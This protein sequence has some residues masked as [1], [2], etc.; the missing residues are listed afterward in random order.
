[1]AFQPLPTINTLQTEIIPG[2][3]S[4]LNGQEMQMDKA[5]NL[6]NTNNLDKNLQ[7]I[8]EKFKLDAEHISS[9]KNL[10]NKD[11]IED[12]NQQLKLMKFSVKNSN[13]IAFNLESFETKYPLACHL[14]RIWS[15][16]ENKLSDS[17]CFAQSKHGDIDYN[18][19][20][21]GFDPHTSAD[22]RLRDI[23]QFSSLTNV[24]TRTDDNH[25]IFRRFNAELRSRNLTGPMQSNLLENK[26]KPT[27]RGNN[28]ACV[29]ILSK[30]SLLS[31]INDFEIIYR[32]IIKG[33]KW[34]S[35]IKFLQ[36]VTQKGF[37]QYCGAFKKYQ[38]IIQLEEKIKTWINKYDHVLSA[39][40]DEST[41]NGCG[42]N[43]IQFNAVLSQKYKSDQH[44]LTH[45]LKL[46]NID[47]TKK[48]MENAAK[49]FA[50]HHQL[51]DD[52]IQPFAKYNVC[53]IC[54]L[55]DADQ[56]ISTCGHVICQKCA[57]NLYCSHNF[58]LMR[59]SLT[60]QEGRCPYCNTDFKS[61]DLKKIYY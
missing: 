51:V 53:R 35:Y 40:K 19:I 25:E 22:I 31:T 8:L 57:D 33:K 3:G 23:W 60:K 11:K 18:Q 55:D 27:I 7:K 15:D 49:I 43:T 41:D 34:R 42:L 14:I 54:L 58:G 12:I 38:Y 28:L 37:E 46:L 21:E 6:S 30:K 59:N 52:F 61:T 47:E 29:Q 32:T 16:F 50:L 45:L 13:K 5:I 24:S 1:M 4:L 26:Q 39:I 48:N 56:F 9:A 44:L 2:F 17:H 10:Y 20:F 36:N